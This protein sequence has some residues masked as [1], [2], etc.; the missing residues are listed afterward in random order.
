MFPPA[1]L[2]VGNKLMETFPLDYE[3]TSV[4]AVF[5]VGIFSCAGSF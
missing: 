2:R 5:L 4:F 1:T 3:N